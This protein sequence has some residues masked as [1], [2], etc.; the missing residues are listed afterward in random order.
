[1]KRISK[2]FV[3][4][5]LI[6]IIAFSCVAVSADEK[7]EE[8]IG[9]Y[10]Y[11]DFIKNI[12][13]NL[14]LLGRYEG[15]VENELYLV[16]LNAI[17]EKN[18]ELYNVAVKA[19]AESI[20]ENSNYYAGDEA[21]KFIES[22]DDE[23]VGIGVT[24][25]ESDG[26]IIVSQPIPDSPADKAGVK[27]GDI[28]V[29]ADDIV[30][31]GMDLDTAID[32]IRGKEGTTVKIT[33]KRS[34]I[35]APININIVREKVMSSSVDFEL[36]ERDDKKIA[37]ITIYSFTENVAMQFK[38]ALDKAEAAGTNKLI[39][40]LRD[41]GG[42]YLDQAVAIADMLLPADKIITTEDYKLDELDRKYMSTGIGRDYE[43]VVLINEMS[44]SASEV[45]TAALV[46]NDAAVSVGKTSFG[47]GTIQTMKFVGKSIYAEE[48]I[49][50]LTGIPNDA[51]M[52]YTVAF[53]LTPNGNNIHKKGITP[54]AIVENSTKPVDMAQ[55]GEFSITKKFSL[56]D[57][58]PEIENAKKMLGFLGVY[59]GEI[60][61]L[62]DENLKSAVTTFQDAMD[63]YPYGVLDF[64]TQVNLLEKMKTMK[65]EVDDQLDAAI[66]SF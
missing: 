50:N 3:A 47:K 32:Y 58:D 7:T 41:N 10:K 51:I 26:N 53:Y 29:A 27:S 66:D 59:Y 37:K 35:N 36:I 52:K 33:I 40:D 54:D 11:S 30:L 34:G 49:K 24:V 2:K 42:G 4:W 61:D 20:D 13:K 14:S 9:E 1:M 46:E 43:I 12:A 21:K 22:L 64:T 63:L 39:I 60:N 45:L 55:F 23:V 18:P 38:E 28:I 8:T 16:A 57:R 6:I 19:M 62:Y 48:Y 31:T 56:G 25:L 44:A 65:I 5:M 15:L 17:L